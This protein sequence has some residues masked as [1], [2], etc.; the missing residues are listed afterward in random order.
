MV[1][2][3]GKHHQLWHQSFTPRSPLQWYC[4]IF[5]GRK[6]DLYTREQVFE[7]LDDTTTTETTTTT[8]KPDRG[9][10]TARQY[11]QE[12]EQEHDDPERYAFSAQCY[13]GLTARQ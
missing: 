11:K 7:I 4:Q 6:Q 8:T 13:P 1:T 12:H 10:I 3:E 5:F 2:L 9:A